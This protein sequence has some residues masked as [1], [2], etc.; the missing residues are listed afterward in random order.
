MPR[1]WT[2]REV[3]AAAADPAIGPH[4][5]DFVKL[6]ALAELLDALEHATG[7]GLPK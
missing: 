5:V 7:R 4:V 3:P 6:I 2:D 1:E